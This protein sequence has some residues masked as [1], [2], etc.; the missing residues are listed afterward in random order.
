MT[1]YNSVVAAIN[2][3]CT[4]HQ[5]I[6]TFYSGQTWNFQ[7][8]TNTYPAMILVPL[9][10]AVE[11]G[12]VVLNFNMFLTDIL[13]K[14]RSNLTEI[15]SDTL[16][17]I[18]DIISELKDD[19]DTYGFTLDESSVSVD[20]FEES[21]D[22]VLAGWIANISIS[23]KFNGSNCILPITPIVIGTPGI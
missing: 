2:D 17:I 20:P 22:D 6:N 19:E 4:R 3:L 16:Q 23:F 21:F 13:N 11:S 12:R 5:Q 14:D 10:S 15:H 1:T 9:T 7:P 8:D 18:G